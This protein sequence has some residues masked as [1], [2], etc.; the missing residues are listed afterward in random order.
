MAFHPFGRALALASLSLIPF[1]AVLA[2][3]SST[4]DGS[5]PGPDDPVLT[6][7]IVVSAVRTDSATRL[8]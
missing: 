8:S 2:N 6:D 7:T 5:D 3:E 1:Q 4:A